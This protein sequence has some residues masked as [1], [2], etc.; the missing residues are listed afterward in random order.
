MPRNR[1]TVL[2]C[3]PGVN[4]ESRPENFR[5]EDCGYPVVQDGK[6]LA[7]TLF[8]SVDPYMRCRMNEDT[9]SHYLSPWQLDHACEGGG[10]GVVIDSKHKDFHPGDYVETWVWPWQEYSQ[11][12]PEGLRKLDPTLFGSRLSLALGA[13]GMP[14]ATAL[15]GIRERGHV[16]PGA[17]QTFV[18]S[19]AAGA[20][21][22]LA[23]QIAR[24]EGA[25]NIVGICGSEEKCRL[26]MEE[27]GFDHAVNYRTDNV[28]DR[29]KEACPRGVDSY[30]DNVGGEISETV[31]KQMNEGSHVILCG[32]ISVYNKDVPYPPPLPQEVTDILKE[33]NITR[34]R[35]LIM[36]YLDKFEESGIQL[37]KWIQEGKLK[38]KETVVEGI[39]KTGEAFVSMMKGGNVGKMIVHVAD[40]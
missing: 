16:T 18:V 28:A 3:R 37:A 10:V 14:G 29:L 12:S 32:Q 21:G 38:V 9:G 27:L 22:S 5:T 24:L 17:N 2:A 1:R 6:V 34:E 40:P 25:A 26:L 39:E 7:K 13:L 15:V 8:L 35:F 11:V 19:G 30:F 23:G 4:G 31:I 20:C 36:N 33:R